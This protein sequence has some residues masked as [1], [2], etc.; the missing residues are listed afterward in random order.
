MGAKGSTTRMLK[1]NEVITVYETLKSYLKLVLGTEEWTYQDG[2]NDEV[3]TKALEG[4][5]PGIS[6]RN[7]AGVR[8][9]CFG[10]LWKPTPERSMGDRI[11]ALE[12]VVADL[13]RKL[14]ETDS[15]IM[16]LSDKLDKQST[17]YLP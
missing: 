12:K 2:Y 11:T 7:V 9:R 13:Y 14:N 17:V 5:I 15:A 3:V 16:A 6:V 8:E 1:T 10:R 4:I